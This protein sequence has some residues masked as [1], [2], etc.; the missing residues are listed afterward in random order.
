MKK[1]PQ[2][3]KYHQQNVF[4]S[5]FKTEKDLS[6]LWT[7]DNIWKMLQI[8]RLEHLFKITA[9]IH[10]AEKMLEAIQKRRAVVSG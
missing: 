3:N 4:R 9:D 2:K 7:A 10:T 8:T 1:N 5:Q 6:Y